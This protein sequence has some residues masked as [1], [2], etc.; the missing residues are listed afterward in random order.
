[1]I[2]GRIFLKRLFLFLVA[3]LFSVHNTFA[4]NGYTHRE[5]IRIAINEYAV[6]PNAEIN[7]VLKAMLMN[8][9]G[10]DED[11][12]SKNNDFYN[13]IEH[14]FGILN[15][16]VNGVH[17]KD[18]DRKY[19]GYKAK[20]PRNVLVYMFQSYKKAVDCWK[21]GHDYEMAMG[22]LGS[23]IRYM[24]DMCC[25]S[26]QSKFRDDCYNE[27]ID[28]KVKENR[29]DLLHLLKLAMGHRKLVFSDVRIIAMNYFEAS[30]KSSIFRGCLPS[31]LSFA[32]EATC[33][34]IDSFCRECGIYVVW[35]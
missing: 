22:C 13:M 26:N 35:T 4:F 25:F 18:I 32:F 19:K 14:H 15:L 21:K 10:A 27:Y 29:T 17:K 30:L 9:G 28:T 34:L 23:A 2:H 5:L 31:D 8:G 1:M 12:N 7:Y 33:Y 24:Q 11:L 6:F 20:N 3:C 16:N